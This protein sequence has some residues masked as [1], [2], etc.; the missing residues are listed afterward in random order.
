[1]RM[2]V[3]ETLRFAGFDVLEQ[4]G[5]H[6]W[7]G[8]RHGARKTAPCGSKTSEWMYTEPYR[9]SHCRDRSHVFVKVTA[10]NNGDKE[11]QTTFAHLRGNLIL[12]E[13][14]R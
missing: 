3:I 12:D 11:R 8:E 6:V 10:G 1:V 14:L 13:G 5:D 9:D 7:R 2:E 4:A